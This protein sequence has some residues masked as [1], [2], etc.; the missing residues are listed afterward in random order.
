[1]QLTD[2]SSKTAITNILTYDSFWCERA[3]FKS[4]VNILIKL[5]NF[6]NSLMLNIPISILVLPL[7]GR[8][9]LNN[10][11]K[12]TINSLKNT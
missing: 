12:N 10:Q 7:Y 2:F 6:R 9:F 8:C 11:I 1:M 3:Y 5:T 4:K